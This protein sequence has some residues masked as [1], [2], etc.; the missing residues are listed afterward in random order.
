MDAGSF[1]QKATGKK[2]ANKKLLAK[3][4]GIKQGEA[5]KLMHEAH[6]KVFSCTDC[7]QCANCCKTTGP[8]FT[9]RDIERISSRLKLTQQAFEQKYLRK[10]EDGDIV[11]QQTPCA[12]LDEKNYCTI[13]DVRPKACREY[14]HTDRVNQQQL[15]HLTLKN[16]IVCPAVFEIL[17]E[18]RKK[19]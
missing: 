14:P 9:A 15:F 11:L 12:F 8:L 18:I 13:Y 1:H 6:E 5:D 16:S 10:D 3:L 2:S 19:V 7:L 4:S 17:E